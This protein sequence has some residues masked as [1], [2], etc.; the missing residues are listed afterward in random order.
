MHGAASQRSGTRG[1][2]RNVGRSCRRFLLIDLVRH[3]LTLALFRA[4]VVPFFSHIAA[5]G[6]IAS[7]RRAYTTAEFARIAD[8]AGVRY[9]HSVSLIYANQTLDIEY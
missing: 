9:R 3:P 4:F 7:I 6:G 1:I 5:A 8:I 2:I